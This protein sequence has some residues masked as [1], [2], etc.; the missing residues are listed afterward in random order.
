MVKDVVVPIALIA[1]VFPIPVTPSGNIVVVTP[2]CAEAQENSRPI[3][4]TSLTLVYSNPCGVV[5][6]TSNNPVVL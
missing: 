2:M 3:S 4:V 6:V 1:K 5:V